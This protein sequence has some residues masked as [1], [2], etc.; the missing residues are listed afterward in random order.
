MERTQW[1]FR[2]FVSRGRLTAIT[3]YF[4]I[5][6]FDE[7]VRDRAAILQKLVAYHD[8]I[9]HRIQPHLMSYGID[10]FI[11]SDGRVS[12]IELN[13]FYTRCGTFNC[14][15]AARSLPTAHAASVPGSSTGK[16][17]LHSSDAHDSARHAA[18]RSAHAGRQTDMKLLVDGDGDCTVMRVMDK[19][20]SASQHDAYQW[21]PLRCVRLVLLRSSAVVPAGRC[22]G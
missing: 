12:T 5:C 21:L 16:Y 13:P 22:E 18:M 11:A 15:I 3:Q 6:Y 7:L 1:E 19:K 10:F 20:A 17:A 8:S 14:L 9:R 4:S 2:G